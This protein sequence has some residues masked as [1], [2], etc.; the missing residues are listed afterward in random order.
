MLVLLHTS[1]C[2]MP[3]V[4]II[5]YLSLIKSTKEKNMEWKKSIPY[6][7]SL[8][9]PY[10][11]TIRTFLL[12]IFVC[13]SYKM[14]V[15]ASSQPV[16]FNRFLLFLLFFIL[17]ILFCV[18][19]ILLLYTFV[20]RDQRTAINYYIAPSFM[21]SSSFF[22]WK[23]YFIRLLLPTGWI[24]VTITRSLDGVVIERW[25]NRSLVTHRSYQLGQVWFN[26]KSMSLLF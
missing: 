2:E 23:Y 6:G 24:C 21:F 8:L 17:F 25:Y 13:I 22:I 7:F 14:H 15:S 19:L 1:T 5:K 10:S 16:P 20:M 11:F 3:V 4:V 9:C 26:E 18:L 12:P